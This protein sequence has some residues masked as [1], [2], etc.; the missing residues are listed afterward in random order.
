MLAATSCGERH[1][2]RA[3]IPKPPL[4]QLPDPTPPPR[5]DGRLPPGVLP[6]AY[7]IELTVDPSQRDFLGRVRIQVAVEQ[8]TR[9][10]VLHGRGLTL[11][12][13]AVETKSGKLWA[14][15]SLRPAAHSKG[16]AEEL[17]LVLEREVPAG[18]AVID[19]QYAGAF[20]EGLRGLYRVQEGGRWYAFTQFEPSDARRAF[21]C[22]DEPSFK[23]PVTLRVSV[24]E[25]QQVLAN[26]PLEGSSA[27]RSA[28]LTTYAFKTSPPLPTYLV[29]LA[30]GP[31]EVASGAKQPT[32]LRVASVPGKSSYSELAL[33]A[34][35]AE[36]PIL[37]AYFGEP[38]PY[39]K[40]DL[41]AVPNFAAGAMEN[42]GLITFREE[43]LLLDARS[44][45]HSA[46]RA[47]A[48]VLAHELAH[49]WFGNLVTMRW[50][51]DLWLNEAFATWMANKVIDRYRPDYAAGLEGVARKLEVM[52]LDAL[53]AARKVRQPVQSTSEALEAFDGITY[54]KGMAV[55]T[56]LESWLG[57]ETFQSGLRAYLTRYKWQNATSADLSTALAEASGK[58]VRAVIDS[59][60][61]QT[62]VPLLQVEL[63]CGR[64]KPGEKAEPVVHFSQSEYRPIGRAAAPPHSWRFPVC[65]RFESKN[66]SDRACVSMN[67][68]KLDVRLGAKKCPRWLA[69]NAEE[70]GYFRWRLPLQALTALAADAQR[71]LTDKERIG[72][73]AGAWA[74]VKSGELRIDAY[75]RILQSFRKEKN[76]VV[77]DQIVES[78]FQMHRNLVDDSVRP[79]FQRW[80]AQLT[81]PV[82]RGI[83]LEA[84]GGDSSETALLRRNLLRALG[85]L[86]ED[87][88]ALETSATQAERWL[89][90][91][92]SADA[93]VAGAALAVR[94]RRGDVALFERILARFRSAASPEQRLIALAG[95]TAFDDPKLLERTLGMV[96][97]GTIKAQDV[98]YVFPP[99][100]DRRASRELAYGFIEGHFAD[101]ERVLPPSVLG[102]LVWIMA[103]LCD[104]ERIARA[105]AFFEPRVS[106]LEGADKHLSQAR[107]AGEL[108]A[109]FAAAHKPT[110][111]T[112]LVQ[113]G[114]G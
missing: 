17:V 67:G 4:V 30:V 107:E 3:P 12:T 73:V 97:D 31:F 29:A 55:L 26:M 72:L 20:A 63:D 65:V 25:G 111:S 27:Q 56:M 75:L 15:G 60:V 8:A 102:R 58:E 112:F 5:A 66:G 40:L 81:E 19:V 99:L 82:V 24:P 68:P 46:R 28:G 18:D 43:L 44:A 53:Q 93:D 2:A 90:D 23:A 80:V 10:I 84:Q 92:A 59:F 94:A 77:W 36:L 49:M 33:E 87:T 41:L 54:T 34:A 106:K 86:A 85:V 110:L 42:P 104:A 9:A 35:A 50:W 95:L 61:D 78:L 52:S 48:G 47:L 109:A 64:A 74:L 32:P 22:F 39:A 76:R 105:R 108:C 57:E 70:A 98:R 21:P 1:T 114:K 89:T 71:L 45:S 11:Q 7:D 38:Y 88:R 103:G 91:P 62:G 101:L 69:P 51:D 37:S 100:F 14:R 6:K 79:A 96:L 16:D 13:A 83:G 113:G